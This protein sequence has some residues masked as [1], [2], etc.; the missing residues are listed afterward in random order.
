MNSNT[1][2][3]TFSPKSINDATAAEWD[4][5]A[6]PALQRQVGGTHYKDLKIQPI[7][8]VMANDMNYCEANIVKY[9]TR[10]HAKGGREDIEKVIH[11]AQL[12]LEMKYGDKK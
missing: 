7:E 11:Y 1:I 12:L 9:V 5:V 10:H 3:Q 6:K 4:S 2:S 8:Y